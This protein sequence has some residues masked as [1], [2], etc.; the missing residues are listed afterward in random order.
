M[1]DYINSISRYNPWNGEK[2]S[3]GLERSFYMD[4]INQFIE[5]RLVKVLVGQ[6]RSGKSFV[7][8]Q[9]INRLIKSG[10]SPHNIL[11]ISKE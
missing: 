6:R 8:K 9:L 3:T 1:T 5:N 11:F 7:L 2:F 4:K 10:V